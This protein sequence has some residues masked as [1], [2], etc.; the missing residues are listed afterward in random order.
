MISTS[1][2]LVFFDLEATGVN[3]QT[4]RIVQ[5]AIIKHDGDKEPEKKLHLIDPG[6]PIPKEATEV[7]GITNEM[8]QGK[9]TF[10]AIAKSLFEYIYLCDFAGY[11]S[12][13]FDFPM[14]IME[15][16]RCGIEFPTWDPFFIDAFEIE[17]I[18]NSHKL[19]D[20][21][22]R[23]TSKDLTDAHD[24]MV[25]TL[26]TREVIMHQSEILWGLEEFGKI[27]TPQT[28]D[29]FCQG[30]N[31]RFDY[32]GKCY[33]KDGEVYWAFG[34]NRDQNVMDDRGYLNWV[35]NSD[36]PLETK[37]KLKNWIIK[38]SKA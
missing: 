29:R 4:D 9:P 37:S 35:I 26:A 1:R 5:I 15:F 7:H 14:L 33:I 25:D 18:L 31:E 10:K 2:P 28:I 24:A 13:S 36:F 12:D 6:G 20:T 38:K 16:H 21:Y 11:N 30:E 32:A 3:I 27:V 34:R 19:S 22:R 8:V 23:Y 17:R